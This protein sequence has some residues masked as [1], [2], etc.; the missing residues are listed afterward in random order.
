MGLSELVTSLVRLS[1]NKAPCCQCTE[2]CCRC[3]PGERRACP[4]PHRGAQGLRSHRAVGLCSSTWP[5]LW[6]RS[7]PTRGERGPARA[8]AAR[9]GH[10]VCSPWAVP[11][12]LS[13]PVCKM[14]P[15]TIVSKRLEV[16]PF[17]ISLEE[18]FLLDKTG[19]TEYVAHTQCIFRECHL[20]RWW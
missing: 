7:C 13:F 2:R 17:Q 12:F 3:I 5:W 8:S 4:A 18:G 9:L 19:K 14:G 16:S 20:N 11:S 15:R 6:S 10:T 1:L